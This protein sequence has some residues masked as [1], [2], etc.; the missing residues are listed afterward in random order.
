[1]YLY[2]LIDIMSAIICVNISCSLFTKH[3]FIFN[4]QI[5][6]EWMDLS[7]SNVNTN[8]S[9]AQFVFKC[10]INN[11]NKISSK[12]EQNCIKLLDHKDIEIFPLAIISY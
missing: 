4:F 10:A 1:M 6:L 12:Y 9:L 3:L 5:Q 8:I 7:Q 2:V 11:I